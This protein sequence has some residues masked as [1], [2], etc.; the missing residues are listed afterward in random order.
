M[1]NRRVLVGGLTVIHL[2]LYA[3]FVGQ[4]LMID[5]RRCDVSCGNLVV[6]LALIWLTPLSW[7]VAAVT[8]ISIYITSPSCRRVCVVSWSALVVTMLSFLAAL[9]FLRP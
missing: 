4:E 8:S 9:L 6:D 7:L 5:S 3:A 2:V 1:R